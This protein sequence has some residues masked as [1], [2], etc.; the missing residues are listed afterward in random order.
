MIAW[1]VLLRVTGKKWSKPNCDLPA[2]IDPLALHRD[3]W[4]GSNSAVAAYKKAPERRGEPGRHLEESEA[5]WVGR[6]YSG[7]PKKGREKEHGC[8]MAIA[9]F[10]DRMCLAL[11]AS[12]LW[13]RYATQQNLIPSFPWIWQPWERDRERCTQRCCCDVVHAC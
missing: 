1:L 9:R 5:W 6:C 10:L 3:M 7:S 11:L 13:L 12:G 8:Q 4:R 2:W